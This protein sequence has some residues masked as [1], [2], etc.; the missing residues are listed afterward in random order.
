M[1]ITGII[2][3]AVLTAFCTT[4]CASS[5]LVHD[6]AYLRAAYIS[7]KDGVS[8]TLA[9]FS[10]NVKPV[11][12][13][14]SDMQQALDTAELSVGRRIFTGFADLVVLDGD[15]PA[16]TLEYVLEEWRVSPSCLVAVSCE[17]EYLLSHRD[18]EQLHGSV[19][20]A[21][22]QGAVPECDIIAVLEDMLGE[23]KAETAELRTDGV[24]IPAVLRD[25]PT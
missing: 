16:E 14:G 25:I 12:A 20:E 24:P 9:F 19:Q 4:G 2:A 18:P 10:E 15:M 1:R 5:G 8:L 7:R 22:R 13:S 17:G 6:K 3:A 23:G 11:T 21:V